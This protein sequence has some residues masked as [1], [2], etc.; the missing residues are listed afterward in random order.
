MGRDERRE[1]ET[2]SEDGTE[3]GV[4]IG[5]RGVI[6]EVG[7]LVKGCSKPSDND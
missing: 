5:V 6:A 7:K 1:L 2:A 3:V 4:G